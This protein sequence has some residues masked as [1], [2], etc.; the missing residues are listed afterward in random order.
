MNWTKVMKYFAYGSN[1]DPERMRERD[2]TSS[3]RRHAILIGYR[4]EFNKVASRNPEE[5][6]A[7]VVQYENGV[8]EGVLYDIRDSDV[9]KL[10]RCE[11]YPEHYDRVKVKVR[12]D[13]KQEMEAVTYIAQPSKIRYGLRPSRDYLDHLLAAEDLLSESYRRMLAALRTLEE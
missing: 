4:L 5:G 2:I 10:D 12:P 1:M 13:V 3:Q 8:V 11:G 9:A 7:N 6:Y